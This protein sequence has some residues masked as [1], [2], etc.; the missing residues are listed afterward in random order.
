MFYSSR[1]VFPR[2]PAAS[3]ARSHGPPLQC[4]NSIGRAFLNEDLLGEAL[5]IPTINV[6]FEH[7][8]LAIDF[9][10]KHA[11]VRDV[12]GARD[13]DL[14]FDFCVGADGS[15]SIVRRQLMRAVR[16][17]CPISSLDIPNPLWALFGPP[18]T[19]LT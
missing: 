5:A 4:I 2:A 9:D 18:E 14:P 6:F 1:P 11:A 16:C 13:L 8:V 3:S 12:Q 10:R 17:V 15:Y 19:V 7:K